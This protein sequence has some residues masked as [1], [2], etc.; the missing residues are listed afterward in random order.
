MHGIGGRVFTRIERR[1]RIT[2]KCWNEALRTH[3]YGPV[4]VTSLERCPVTTDMMILQV[5]S[6]V[7]ARPGRATRSC[8]RKMLCK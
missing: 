2:K 3:L 1:I 5:H 4:G 6:G 7:D 8:I